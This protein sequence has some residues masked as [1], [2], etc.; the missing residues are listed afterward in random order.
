MDELRAEL[1]AADSAAKA[2]ALLGGP[3]VKAVRDYKTS[4]RYEFTDSGVNITDIDLPKSNVL[5]YELG[6]DKGI[7]WACARPSGTEPKLKIYFGCYDSDKD[8]ATARLASVK[9]SVTGFIEGKLK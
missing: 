2:G 1:E 7:D 4:K 3:E 8:A 5:L 6:G 9:A